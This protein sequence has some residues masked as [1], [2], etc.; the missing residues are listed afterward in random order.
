MDYKKINRDSWD[1][2]VESQDQWTV[3]VSK[4]EMELAKKGEWGIVLTPYKKIPRDWFPKEM[5]GTKILC[6]ASGGGQQ[7][8]ILSAAGADVTVF[9]YSPKQL[10]QDNFVAKRDH[11][12]LKTVQ[13]D[14]IDLSVFADESFH[15]IVHPWSN[16]AV[17]DINPVWRECYRVLK[18]GGAL[19]SGFG[20]PLEYIFDLEKY[21]NNILE[22][23]HSIPYSDLTSIS[24]EE[25]E[26]LIYSRNEVILFGHSLE[27]QI[28]G[29][30][31]A[32][33]V[34]T[35]FYEDKSGCA[36]DPYINTGMATKAVKF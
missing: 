31:R 29:Q 25:R 5:K 26:K 23:R 16:C 28:G 11:L 19:L 20:N 15:L 32:G 10:E 33:F 36:L 8:P 12:D 34:I 6:L 30:L 18:H 4:E 35:G 9:D 13:G 2:K 21:E 7:G 27:D 14:M 1:S 17:D 24:D 3:P 22:V